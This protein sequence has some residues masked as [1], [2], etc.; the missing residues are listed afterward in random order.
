MAQQFPF[1]LVIQSPRLDATVPNI[2]LFCRL[3]S[4]LK[5]TIGLDNPL[6][7][8]FC[9]KMALHGMFIYILIP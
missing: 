6:D 5:K 3:L 2:Q 4:F 8:Q 1:L 9:V 7:C